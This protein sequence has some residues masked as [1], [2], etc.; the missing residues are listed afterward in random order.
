MDDIK[1]LTHPPPHAQTEAAEKKAAA[2][3]KS[4]PGKF[5]KEQEAKKKVRVWVE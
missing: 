4:D 3:K 1:R 2:A 5:L